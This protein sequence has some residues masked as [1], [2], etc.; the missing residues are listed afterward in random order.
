MHKYSERPLLLFGYIGIILFIFAL[1]S[2]F[3]SLYEKIFLDLNLN[4]NGWFFISLFL[5]IGSIILFSFGII[6]DLL[7]KIN[8][9]NNPNDKRYLIKEILIK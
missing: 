4:R 7:I 1:F 9:K 3:W 5:F 2:G 8:F 6:M